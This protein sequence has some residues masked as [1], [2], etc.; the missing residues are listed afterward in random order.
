VA[1]P[2]I[3]REFVGGSWRTRRESSSGGSQP[4][5][6]VAVSSAE[7][8][9]LNDS[10][11]EIVPAPGAN[12]VT[13]IVSIAAIY[14]A[15]TTGYTQPSGAPTIGHLGTFLND[16]AYLTQPPCDLTQATN[17]NGGV[18]SS[19]QAETS[20]ELENFINQP[21]V[22]ASGANLEDG[23]GDLVLTIAYVTL[24]LA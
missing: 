9:A 19:A 21:I 8:L 20:I 16:G 22:L 2:Q 24:D 5:V 11:V 7:L 15:G 3:V 13:P 23:D 10:P 4:A 18:G 6:T 12:K 1:V 14:N 17:T